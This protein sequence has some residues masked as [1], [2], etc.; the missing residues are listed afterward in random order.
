[1]PD[2]K[3]ERQDRESTQAYE[4]FVTYRDLGVGRTFAAVAEK[5]SK[6]YTLIRRWKDAWNWEERAASWDNEL[7]EKAI[8]TAAAD[9]AKM[10]EL[11][12]GIGK[13]MQ[14]K[15]AKG[16]QGMDFDG[17]PVK[18]LPSVVNLI[19]SGMKAERTARDIKSQR[20]ATR[21][22]ELIINIVPRFIEGEEARGK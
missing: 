20:Q 10:L 18:Y 22:N 6:S 13:M 5:L 3:W 1:M 12:I 8:K 11:Q 2:K 19:N 9:Y 7:A 4:A 21:N 15:G 17:M 16:L 14:S